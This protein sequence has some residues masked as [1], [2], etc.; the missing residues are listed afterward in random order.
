MNNLKGICLA[1][2]LSLS[3][4]TANAEIITF[5]DLSTDSTYNIIAD[6]EIGREYLRFNT[7]NLSYEET[8]SE[9]ES[10]GDY[11]GWS[12]ADSIISDDFLNGLLSK[13]GGNACLLTVR[14]CGTISGWFDGALGDTWDVNYDN[15]L[16]ISDTPGHVATIDFLANGSII[17]YGTWT[18]FSNGDNYAIDYL[19][20][21]EN[22]LHLGGFNINAAKNNLV[23]DSV[24]VPEPAT[25]GMFLLTLAGI[26]LRKKRSEKLF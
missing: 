4:I 12:I 18:T 20:Y 24:S 23:S 10:G 7:A 16:Y 19:L 14:S 3:S 5:G 22:T 17:K 6:T 8:I 11:E 2:F 9:I 1:S 21:R 13:D 25:I 15:Y 26:S